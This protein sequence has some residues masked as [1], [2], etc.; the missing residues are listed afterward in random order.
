[1]SAAVFA[2]LTLLVSGGGPT[3]PWCDPMWL[4]ISRAP[5]AAALVVRFAADTVPDLPAPTFA[6]AGPAESLRESVAGRRGPRRPRYAQLA[7]VAD[8]HGAA[9]AGA[10]V[11]LVPWE[12]AMDCRPSPWMSSW[13]WAA[14]GD[15]GFL[16]AWLRP[17]AGWIAGKAT[18]DVEVRGWQPMW[19]REDP[20]WPHGRDSLLTPVEFRRVYELLPA[21]STLADTTAMRRALATLR[22][23][24]P[25]LIRRE[26]ARSMVA[27][28]ALAANARAADTVAVTVKSSSSTLAFEPDEITVKHGTVVRLRF[29][30]TGTLPHNFVLVKNEDDLDA[31]AMAAMEEG[32]DYVPRDMK[33]KLFAFTKLA[34][35]SQTVEVVFPAPPPGLYTYVCLMSGHAAMMLGKLR[36]VR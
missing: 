4:P 33:D 23:R 24:V 29:V 1:M 16:F 3:I 17:E 6:A 32:G 26:P 35:P 11:A 7:Q 27:N 2:A 13:R 20:R 22:A 18:F 34:S 8:D 5:G 10:Q 25:E 28:L 31:L 15:E 14:P 30:N 9:G 21:H 12:F 36:S 19:R